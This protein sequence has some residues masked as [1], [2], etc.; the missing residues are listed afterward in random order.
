MVVVRCEIKAKSPE[1]IRALC[2]DLYYLISIN[3]I[4]DGVELLRQLYFILFHGVTGIVGLTRFL[5]DSVAALE[6]E[7][8]VT[9]FNDRSRS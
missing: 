3:S 6:G 5:V 2:F 9:P 7:T 8:V 1:A 4:A